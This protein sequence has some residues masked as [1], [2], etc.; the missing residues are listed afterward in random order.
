MMENK[1]KSFF[2]PLAICEIN[3]KLDFIEFDI[4]KWTK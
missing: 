2:K 4:R 3:Y 1:A